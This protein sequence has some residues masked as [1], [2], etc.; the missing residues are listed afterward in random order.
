MKELEPHEAKEIMLG[1]LKYVTDFCNSNNIK[2]ILSDGTLLGAVRHKGFIPWDMDIDIS[3]LRNDYDKFIELWEN[4]ESYT[5]LYPGIDKKY[6]L[7]F[8]KIVHNDTIAYENNRKTFYGGPWIDIFPLDAVPLENFD[9]HYVKILKLY[10]NYRFLFICGKRSSNKFIYFL[11]TLKQAI[12]TMNLKLVFCS[13]NKALK[14][15]VTEST[16]FNS[17]KHICVTNNMVIGRR[18]GR[19]KFGFN[20]DVVSNVMNGS[21]EGYNFKIPVHYDELL[22]SYYDDYMTLPPKEKQIDDHSAR[23]F[24]NKKQS[25]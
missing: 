11:R 10:D 5:L 8:L 18:T 17:S 23:F 13:P 1:I 19:R 4:T 3:M 2:Y 6:Q 20:K 21:F 22:K 14:K 15:L 24:W 7:G 9:K 12:K 16:K 25:L